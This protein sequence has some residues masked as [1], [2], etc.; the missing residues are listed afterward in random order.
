MEKIMENLKN[1]KQDLIE[2]LEDTISMV[3]DIY[4]ESYEKAMQS[5]DRNFRTT[6]NKLEVLKDRLVDFNIEE[7]ELLVQS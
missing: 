4:N 6:I 3:C 1:K 5:D 7:L 2:R